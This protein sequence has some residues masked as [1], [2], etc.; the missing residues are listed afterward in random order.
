[1]AIQLQTLSGS[2]RAAQDGMEWIINFAKQTPLRLEQV[3]DAFVK[4]TAVGLRPMDGQLRALSD[5]VA[6]FGGTDQQFWRATIAIQQMAAKGVISMEE[7][8][9]QL[10][11]AIPTAALVMARELGMSMKEMTELISRGGLESNRGLTALFRGLEKSFGGASLKMMQTYSGALSNLQVELT[12][13]MRAIGETGVLDTFTSWVR[14]TTGLVRDL[15]R[16]VT[17]WRTTVAD[18]IDSMATWTRDNEDLA[19]TLFAAA[20]AFLAVKAATLGATVAMGALSA[21]TAL[22]YTVLAGPAGLAAIA[23]GMFVAWKTNLLGMQDTLR[24]FGQVS[25]ITFLAIG[26]T[27]TT[28]FATAWQGAKDILTGKASLA[29][30]GR[31]LSLRLG[32]VWEDAVREAGAHVQAM[33]DTPAGQL[34]ESGLERVQKFAAEIKTMFGPGGL[35]GRALAGEIGFDQLLAAMRKLFDATRREIE[36]TGKALRQSGTLDVLD[37]VQGMWTANTNGVGNAGNGNA[38]TAGAD[39]FWKMFFDKGESILGRLTDRFLG[40]SGA[41]GGLG[42]AGLEGAA[43]AEAKKMNQGAVAAATIAAEFVTTS[44]VYKRFVEKLDQVVALLQTALEPLEPV[45][46]LIADVLRS[47]AGFIVPIARALIQAQ[48]ALSG[49]TQALRFVSKIMQE[50][51]RIFGIQITG[52]D[53]ETVQQLAETGSVELRLDASQ[54]MQELKRA[55][56]AILGAGDAVTREAARQRFLSAREAAVLAEGRARG[57]QPT[58]PDPGVEI[59]GGLLGGLI[60]ALRLLAD[61]LEALVGGVGDAAQRLWDGLVALPGVLR[62]MVTGTVG[63]VRDLLTDLPGLVGAAV[64]DAVGLLGAMLTNFPAHVAN[65]MAGV[66]GDLAG[67][68]VDFWGALREGITGFWGDFIDGLTGAVGQLWQT[69]KDAFRAA[70]TDAL[71][72]S[73]PFIGGGRG[74]VEKALGIDFPWLRFA[75]GGVVPGVYTGRDDTVPALLTPGERVL[76]RQ[77]SQTLGLGLPNPI[78][79]IR[80]VGDAVGGAVGD[81]GRRVAGEAR[82]ILDRLGINGV[83]DWLLARVWGWLRD[84]MQP[85]GFYGARTAMG[86]ATGANLVAGGGYTLHAGEAVLPAR[87]NPSAPAFD[88]RAFWAPALEAFSA[89]TGGGGAGAGQPIIVVVDSAGNASRADTSSDARERILPALRFLERNGYIQPTTAS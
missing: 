85:T 83:W 61:A 60:D 70:I 9:Q 39:S 64:A 16:I 31:D 56:D 46:T 68:V 79:I 23:V 57:T 1:M 18:V 45:L 89:M 26:D 51:L 8:R 37:R 58:A 36:N 73:V 38:A 13:L 50:L 63:Q 29:D 4:L 47:V 28:T 74:P 10:A 54:A 62:D 27:I 49:I 33:R 40:A 82:D 87:Y 75:G 12:Q 65:A 5:A 24:E 53:W 15:T 59:V 41:V 72:F 69:L 7:I 17:D 21:A 43:F 22:L 77:Q 25:K 86:L 20:G 30:V 34:V 44:A 71:S 81:L 78:D 11:E 35:I 32:L 52:A 76:T 42:G 66:W 88:P 6:A 3:T 84:L 67:V 2:G 55:Q 19:F 48:I 80:D 14:E